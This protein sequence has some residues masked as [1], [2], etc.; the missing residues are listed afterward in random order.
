VNTKASLE[1]YS[2]ILLV[3]KLQGYF[4]LMKPRV[5]SLVI[6]TAFVGMFLAPGRIEYLNYIF[7]ILAIA[8]GAGSSAS[9][10][11][12]FDEDI[13]RTMERTKTRP[14]PLG[15][16]TKNEALV[17]GIF[18]G[19][20]SLLLMQW[21]AN[22]LATSL[23]LFTILFYIFIYT[24][25]L[26]RTTS[27]NIVIGG[28]A[29]AIPPI[30]G[31]TAV[32]PEISFLPI[33][34]FLIIFF[35][36]PPHFWALSVYRYNDYENAK[37]PMLPNVKSIYDTKKQIVYYTALLIIFSYSPYL[38]KNIGLIYFVIATILNFILLSSSIKLR[39]TKEKK[40]KPNKEGLK[41]FALSIFY[42]F[43]LFSALVID[44]LIKI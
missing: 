30:I 20:I 26:K 11:M 39:K 1:N 36:T 33:S 25:W 32:S 28:A 31:W 27:L 7:V 43:S 22:P 2:D 40:S 29:G 5:M 10:N 42:L 4:E 14:I 24:F 9:I 3:R 17:L 15:I 35:W 37:V 21:F 38:D 44:H 18:S 41:F 12:W 16:V 34:M 6:F 19:I 23:L 13:D 8:I